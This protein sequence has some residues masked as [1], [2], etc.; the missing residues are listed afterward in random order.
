MRRSGRLPTA[1]AVCL[2]VGAAPSFAQLHS[3]RR[4]S[5]AVETSPVATRLMQTVLGLAAAERWD[6]ALDVL[7]DLQSRDPD[8]LVEV[9]PRRVVRAALVA[10]VLRT[11]F[12]DEHLANYQT[13]FDQTANELLQTGLSGDDPLRLQ[14]ILDRLAATSAGAEAASQLAE[15]LWRRGELDAAAAIW[16]L[17]IPRDAPRIVDAAGPLR[18]P[19]PQL[20][21]ADLAVRRLLVDIFLHDSVAADRKL[22]QFTQLHANAT[23]KLDGRGDLLADILSDVVAAEQEAMIE[24]AI[25]ADESHS[26]D[27]GRLAWHRP[28]RCEPPGRRLTPTPML[29]D[30]R[31]ATAVPVV[32]AGRIFWSDANAVRAVDMD[33]NP[34][35][36]TDKEAQDNRIY[37]TGYPGVASLEFPL[38]GEAAREVSISKGRLFALLGPP[39]S[40]PAEREPRPIESRLVCLDTDQAQGK[41]LWSRRPFDLLTKDDWRYS[42]S[43]LARRDRVYIPVRRSRPS[44]AIGVACLD[45]QDGALLWFQHL[46]GILDDSPATHHLVTSDG[47]AAAYNRL[48]LSGDFGATACLDDVTGRVEWIRR[49]QPAPWTVSPL[50]PESETEG[51]RSLC[52]RGAVYAIEHDDH[53]VVALDARTGTTL[54]RQ[55]IPSRL[56]T[57]AAER[58]GLV[59]A[60]GD[61]LWGLDQQTGAVHWRFGFDD[62]EGHLLGQA[63]LVLPSAPSQAAAVLACSQSELWR[64]NASSGAPEARL[65]LNELHDLQGGRL[66]RAGNRLLIFA[67]DQIAALE[68]PSGGSP[69]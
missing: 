31:M 39:I 61:H 26:L 45:A 56:R 65:P 12:P 49:D 8:A 15:F 25:H 62:P 40:V 69:P 59:F 67:L 19:A 64:I 13:R 66:T 30:T 37:M 50:V 34:L 24:H 17:L 47:L 68:W 6:R 16:R 7:D 43:P 23:G 52:H 9:E 33:G 58:H 27:R 4:E 22:H 20:S 35:W 5:V 54:W 21:T 10:Q 42:G 60:V 3:I 48:Y 41:L 2:L 1:T 38:L 46:A 57:L 36:S 55:S 44:M 63:I 29:R 32:S 14:R 51:R 53:T 28:L 18:I 11:A